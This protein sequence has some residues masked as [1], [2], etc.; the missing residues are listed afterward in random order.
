MTLIRS[1]LL[2]LLILLAP[3]RGWASEPPKPAD[4]TVV[5]ALSKPTLEI[6]LN[7]SDAASAERFFKEG[8]GLTQRPEP[9][10]MRGGGMRMLMFEAGRS[11]SVI[12]VRVYPTP[13]AKKP[14][15]LLGVGGIRVVTLRV[16]NLDQ[17]VARVR[18][19]GFEAADPKPVDGVAG[20]RSSLVRNG[21][22]T[23][24][25]LVEVAADRGRG[26][27]IEIG[28]VVRDLA[29]AK[30]FFTGMYGAKEVLVQDA[31]NRL[32]PGKPMARFATGEGSGTIFNLWSPAEGG[33]AAPGD[34]AG[35][36]PE[37]LGFRYITHSVRDTAALYDAIIAAEAQIDTP[38][39]AFGNSASLFMVRGPGG[40]IFEF[41]GPPTKRAGAPA[42]APKQADASVVPAQVRAMF[43]RV[44]RDRDGVLTPRELPNAERFKQ[45]DADGDGKVTI[46]EAARSLSAG[47]DGAGQDRPGRTAG[48]QEGS[49]VPP[50]GREASPPKDGP[51]LDLVFTTDF[52]ASLMPPGSALRDATEAN[53]LV[54]HNGMLY[55]ATSYMPESGRLGDLNPKVLVKRS[56]DG[57]WE[58]DFE[59]GSDF[60]RL[61]FMR[62]V[63]F[64]TDGQGRKLPK[65]VSVLIAGTGAWRSQPTGV[66]VFSRND[67]TSTWV[68]T[69]LSPDRWNRERTNHST[70]VRCIFDHM[71]RVTG[72][73]M[74][75]AG[76][77]TGRIYRG[78]YDPTEPGLIRWNKTPEID[79]L[80]GHVLCAAEAN[81]VQYAGIAYGPTAE[82]RRQV[83]ERPI[84]DHGLFRRI[85]GPTPRWEWVP[86]KAWEDPEQSGRS[87][88][89]AQLRGMTAVPAADGQGEELLVA[90][91]TRDA[92]I[93]R[94]DPRNG[95][96]STV[97]LDVRAFMREAW[98]RNIG[99]S[100]FAYN[101][102]LPATDPRTG[103][104]VHLIGL[105]L[106]DPRGEVDA[107]GRSSWYLVRNGPGQYAYQR[108]W[109]P[110]NPLDGQPYGLRGCRS[111]VPSPFTGEAGRVWYFCGF[112]QTGAT[113]RDGAKGPMAWIYKGTLPA[114]ENP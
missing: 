106:V 84:K 72:V 19:L 68:R 14:A 7:A 59:A 40:A 39:S 61:G 29:A 20:K 50:P 8:L 9:R 31:A 111:I 28:L 44:D 27:P 76:S 67:E 60:M 79:G 15:E 24:F 88:R 71:D 70:E 49:P 38:L 45:M 78:V 12:K 64:T 95:Y 51:L 96:A 91:D 16:E 90:W 42:D 80:A 75:F 57:P 46:E 92:V 43:E 37:S 107:V 52:H 65:P 26:A 100:T 87:L 62:S 63:A 48:G 109:D 11:G 47:R 23:A 36:I 104:T 5:A 1:F 33:A 21:D 93:E 56:A 105:W 13:P 83:R 108:I 114:K 25:E 54:P 101:D 94:I 99:I 81:G 22:G 66:V 4:L 102:M 32:F 3:P 10:G 30:A 18:Q 89:T 85:D 113:G 2:M 97:E 35:K 69:E 77:A 55:C 74:V 34:D 58:V 103:R 53:V 17:I 112:D 73:H 82:D 110:A 6:C 86:I 98:G 41:V